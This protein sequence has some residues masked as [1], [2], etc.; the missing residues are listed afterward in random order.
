MLAPVFSQ[1]RTS[2]VLAFL[3]SVR[4]IFRKSVESASDKSPHSGPTYYQDNHGVS[5][6]ENA[7][8]AIADPVSLF[9]I[10]CG[11]VAVAS[12][13]FLLVQFVRARSRKH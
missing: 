11:A 6:A 12:S 8:N 9:S 5:P 13:A 4:T 7:A 1:A 2:V 10:V 3:I